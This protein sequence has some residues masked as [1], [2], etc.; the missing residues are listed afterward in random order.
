MI[1]GGD[2]WPPGRRLALATRQGRDIDN[3]QREEW[4]AFR[5][6]AGAELLGRDF[7]EA[8]LRSLSASYNCFGLA[9]ATRRTC[10]E[11]EQL[12]MILHDD[13]YRQ[14]ADERDV[15]AGDLALYRRRDGQVEHVAIVLRVDPDV[16]AAR[17]RFVVL[18]KWGAN[19]EY[20]HEL[21]HLPLTSGLEV[22][23][24]FYSERRMP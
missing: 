12:A 1:V 22:S 13:G 17:F 15:R 9:F 6:R 8:E 2:V 4:P 3:T 10:I 19:G 16:G 21:R 18:S 5:L 7:P 20:V 23:V 24:E 11:P 14:V